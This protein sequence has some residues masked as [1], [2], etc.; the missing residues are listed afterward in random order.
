MSGYGALTQKDIG[1]LESVLLDYRGRSLRLLEIGI[2]TGTTARGIR[3]FCTKQGTT[4]QYFGLDNGAQCSGEPPFEGATVIIGDSVES[5]HLLP[6]KFDVVI[7][8]GDHSFNHVILDTVIYG[9]KVVNGGFILHHDIAPHIQQTMREGHGPDVPRFYNSVNAALE[10][11]HWPWYGWAHCV[12]DWDT[13]VAWGGMSA[14][15]KL[16]P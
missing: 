2:H 4:L 12:S 15:R 7:V 11:I 14:H 3:D 1:V 16:I 9:E 8:D 5:A 10:A 13:Q 6:D